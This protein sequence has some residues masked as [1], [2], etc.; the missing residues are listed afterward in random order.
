[1]QKAVTGKSNGNRCGR[2]GWGDREGAFM[3]LRVFVVT[4]IGRWREENQDALFVDEGS[5]LF[6]IADGMGGLEQGSLAA[7]FAVQEK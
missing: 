3:K 5:G 6:I 7:R 1:V 2:S 4:D